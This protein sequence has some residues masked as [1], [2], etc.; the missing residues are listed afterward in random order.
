MSYNVINIVCLRHGTKMASTFF[1][2]DI[3]KSGL[4]N[5]QAA[6]NTTAHN[7][8]NADTEGYSRQSV[9]QAASIPI[10]VSSNYGM[11]GT[12]VDITAI[13]Q[14]RSSYYD[15]KYWDNNKLVGEY[16]TKEYYMLEIEGYFN[17]LNTDGFTTSF[18]N[19][20]LGLEELSKN[21]SSESVRVEVTNYAQNFAEYM[22]YMSS[23]IDSVQSEANSE[24]N[25]VVNRINSIADQIAGLTREINSI[26][27]TGKYRANDLRDSRATL[28]DEL[29]EIANI[30]ADEIVHT[31]AEGVTE[32]R[33]RLDGQILVDTYNVTTLKCVP[34]ER[35][36]NQ[37]DIDGLFDLEWSNGVKLNMGS[38]TLG[39]S[40]QALIEVRDGNSQGNLQGTANGSAG[41]TELVVTATNINNIDDMNMPLTGMIKV[42]SKEYIYNN[43]TVEISE[44][45]DGNPSFVYTFELDEELRIDAND[46]TASIGSSI[47][48][49]GTCYYQNK[50]NQFTRVFARQ[51]NEI[52]KQGV[53]LNGEFGLDFFTPTGVESSVFDLTG[54][55]YTEA[56]DDETTGILYG[57]ETSYYTLTSSNITVNPDI[58]SHVDKIACASPDKQEDGLIYNGV[59]N[60]DILKKLYALQS[61]RNMF[62]QGTPVSFLETMTAE[63]GIDSKKAQD[64]SEAQGN[65]QASIQNQRLSVMSVDEDEEALNLVK[66]QNSYNL[67]CH[68]VTTMNEIYDKLINGTG[69]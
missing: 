28:V 26:E 65:I 56:E 68:V 13:T 55:E 16:G 10:N 33:V 51:F 15:T 35:K 24:I 59:E 25:N 32:Y 69:A 62:K 29:S 23:C 57:T 34:R 5:Y 58:Y 63:I 9:V 43:F 19:L 44:D 53:D 48:Y 27:A 37:S 21:P 49:K 64:L 52:H 3:A 54:T 1:G 11:Q 2:L 61:D 20:F 4:Y 46:A 36:I 45:D 12:G 18:D 22:N 8:A 7:I 66:F 60:T 38:E 47:N 67:N 6:L 41:D 31:G 30:T 14:T 39:G 50:L 40:L 17:E 42:G